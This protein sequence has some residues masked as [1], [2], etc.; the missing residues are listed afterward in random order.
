MRPA[1]RQPSATLPTRPTVHEVAAA[2]NIAFPDKAPFRVGRAIEELRFGH[3]IWPHAAGERK[4]ALRMFAY[5]EVPDED[6]TA[7]DGTAIVF[8]R[9]GAPDEDGLSPLGIVHA[10][11][12]FFGGRVTSADGVTE[13]F[14]RHPSPPAFSARDRFVLEVEKSQGC[15]DAIALARIADDPAR[16]AALAK[17]VD[18]YRAEAP[19]LSPAGL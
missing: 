10:L 9:N 11:A 6:D 8:G 4:S 17:A 2:L 12:S 7:T 13:T 19:L 3:P 18:T 15:D 5:T 14:E 1:P 16:L